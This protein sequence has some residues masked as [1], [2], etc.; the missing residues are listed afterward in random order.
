MEV[1]VKAVALCPINSQPAPNKHQNNISHHFLSVTASF[2]R[3]ETHDTL[4]MNSGR[5]RGWGIVVSRGDFSHVSHPWLSYWEWQEDAQLNLWGLNSFFVFLSKPC[6][7]FFCNTMM[8]NKKNGINT[9]TTIFS[10]SNNVCIVFVQGSWGDLFY[11]P[12]WH[13]NE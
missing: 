5:W 9:N 13:L 6:E 1:P 3:S 4:L 10:Y 7:S 8:K 11:Y 12:L 2:E